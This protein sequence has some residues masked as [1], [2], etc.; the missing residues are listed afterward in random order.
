MQTNLII[1]LTQKLEPNKPSDPDYKKS[2][3]DNNKKSV[4]EDESFDSSF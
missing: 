4:N 1:A 3:S 2:S